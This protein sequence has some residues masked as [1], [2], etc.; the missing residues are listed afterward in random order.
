[1]SQSP[2]VS[3]STKRW[4]LVLAVFGQF[5][6]PFDSNVVNLAIPSIGKDL[7]GSIESLSWI[8]TGYLIVNC[9]LT[10]ISWKGG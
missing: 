6:G 8:I 7:G 1:M 4:V 10:L 5:M 9:S 2:V 3:R